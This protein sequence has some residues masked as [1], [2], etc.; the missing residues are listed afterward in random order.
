MNYELVTT[1][2]IRR[3]RECL[4]AVSP[5]LKYCRQCGASQIAAATSRLSDE[6][7][8]KG[9]E[10]PEGYHALSGTL[11]RTVVLSLS[12]SPQLRVKSRLGKA[13][14]QT[15]ISMPILI[16]IVLLAPFDAY[17]ATREILQEP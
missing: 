12:S 7:S 16:L 9:T 17:S 3:C 1:I 10:R 5:H 4:A 8:N 14:L 2:E 6:G 11:V 13:V 15:L